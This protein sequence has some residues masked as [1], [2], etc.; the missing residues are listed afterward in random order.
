MRHIGIDGGIAIT[1]VVRIDFG[2]CGGVGVGIQSG[3]AI[4]VITRQT[5][6]KARIADLATVI[7]VARQGAT[8]TG[9]QRRAE[10]GRAATLPGELLDHTPDGFRAVE[11]R[12]VATHDFD[13]LDL[14]QR[15]R[16]QRRGADGGG[17]D[18]HAVQQDE[19]V[20]RIGTAHEY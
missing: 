12:N 2:A 19:R 7:Q 14:F 3:E 15:Q 5:D 8:R 17:I 10:R 9:G 18:A 4:G 1:V 11:R 20:V 16:F 6:V 13:T